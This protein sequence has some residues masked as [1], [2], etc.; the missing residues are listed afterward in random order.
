MK[1]FSNMS[2]FQGELF[3]PEPDLSVAID[4]SEGESAGSS[5]N[6]TIPRKMSNSPVRMND[7]FQE[8]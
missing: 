3:F 2:H 4:L 5:V 7:K 6:R 8:V 1:V